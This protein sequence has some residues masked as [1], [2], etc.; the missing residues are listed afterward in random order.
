MTSIETIRCTI[1]RDFTDG[2]FS[3]RQCLELIKAMP[4]IGLQND[5]GFTWFD[6][7]YRDLKMM[8]AGYMPVCRDVRLWRERT[9]YGLKVRPHR[10]MVTKNRFERISA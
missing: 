8:E 9:D 4:K 5:D 7:F 2:V 6:F 10:E 1:E 3:P